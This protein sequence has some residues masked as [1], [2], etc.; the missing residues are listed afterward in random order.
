MSDN[1]EF[2]MPERPT[3]PNPALRTLDRLIGEWMVD[4]D[5]MSGKIR[6]E[7]ME[8]G[9]FL[10]QHVDLLHDGR[11]ITGMEIIGWD[12][13]RQVLASQFFGNDGIIFP[14]VW[15]VDND[16]LTIW[17]GEVGSAAKY[18]GKFSDD[19][20][21]NSGAWEWPGGGYRSSMTRA[22]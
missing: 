21:S 1:T 8:G 12:E 7:W 11:K 22:S 19:G 2:Q 5:N 16:T 20:N 4:G 18:E 15:V 17:G 6:F 10:V 14:Y 9:Y 13:A 3:S